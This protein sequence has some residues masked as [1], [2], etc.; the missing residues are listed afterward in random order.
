VCEKNIGSLL[1]SEFICVS[2]KCAKNFT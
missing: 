2:K 1:T